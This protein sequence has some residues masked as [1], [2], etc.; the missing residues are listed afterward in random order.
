MVDLKS[1]TL[2]DRFKEYS[3][4]I[5]EGGYKVYENDLEAFR[6]LFRTFAK[7]SEGIII[8]GFTGG[9]KTLTMQI[10]Q[11][12]VSPKDKRYFFMTNC[13]SVVDDYSINGRECFEKYKLKN[14]LFDDLGNEPDGYY[15]GA[16]INVFEEF[17]Q[18][19]Y[20]EFRM[21]GTL[22][23]FTT[24]L[25]KE[26][27][28]TRYGKRCLSRLMEISNYFQFRKKISENDNRNLRNFKGFQQ[29]VYLDDETKEDIEWK[30]KYAEYKERMKALPQVPILY[31]E[32]ISNVVKNQTPKEN[33]FDLIN[34]L[35]KLWL[36]QFDRRFEKRGSDNGVKYIPVFINKEEKYFA[37]SEWL[38][39]KRNK[40]R[41]IIN[42]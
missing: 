3:S 18:R 2:S 19:R 41:L 40:N 33:P 20:D 34:K 23:H 13:L 26:E 35:T 6:A 17:I 8:Q 27:I 1:N 24:N 39:Y 14:Y 28:E 5:L 29:V 37:I 10:F 32:S 21:N 38:E 4:I 42:T 12:I 30:K 9:G 22:T 15:Y 7:G 16:R 25:S 31:N 36:N 11:R